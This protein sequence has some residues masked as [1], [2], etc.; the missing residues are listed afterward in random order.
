MLGSLE[1]ELHFFSMIRS[2]TRIA[3]SNRLRPCY[4]RRL[5]AENYTPRLHR[6]ITTY[7]SMSETV[8]PKAIEYESAPLVWVDC[9]MTGLDYRKDK[10]LEI[11]V[12]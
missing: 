11:A 9:E 12:F 8:E 7:A 5:R 1:S 10:I 3:N 6:R 4:S 2:F